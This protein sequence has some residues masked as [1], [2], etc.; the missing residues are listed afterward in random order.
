MEMSGIDLKD[1][2]DWLFFFGE[3]FFEDIYKLVSLSV[4]DYDMNS[5]R[6]YNTELNHSIFN[7]SNS[8]ERNFVPLAFDAIHAQQNNNYLTIQPEIKEGLVRNAMS[9]T[10]DWRLLLGQFRNYLQQ[11]YLNSLEDQNF[12]LYYSATTFGDTG[13]TQQKDVLLQEVLSDIDLAIN[14]SNTIK[15]S[16]N[17]DD[18]STASKQLKESYYLLSGIGGPT[19]LLSSKIVKDYMKAG[20]AA[21][22]ESIT[23]TGVIGVIFLFIILA[24]PPLFWVWMWVNCLRRKGKFHHLNKIGWFLIIFLGYPF[25]PLG[26]IVYFFLE[27]RKRNK[28]GGRGL[29]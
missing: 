11:K 20:T 24:A 4:I 6:A 16:I 2:D 12:V 10:E 23:I 9:I 14:K 7:I 15:F 29:K 22:Q 19:Q 3:P 26:A 8:K 28:T 13:E 27:Y 18:Y 17:N 1:S 25:F 21:I 5:L